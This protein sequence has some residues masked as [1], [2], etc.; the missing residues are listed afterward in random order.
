MKIEK[1]DMVMVYDGGG[2]VF[3]QQ[4]GRVLSSG[5][6][7]TPLVFDLCNNFA[8]ITVA[9]GT[10]GRMEKTY[11]EMKDAGEHPAFSP[12]DFKVVG[13]ALEIKQLAAELQSAMNPLFSIDDKISFLEK[14]ARANGGRL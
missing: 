11:R 12:S 13:K 10:C 5:G 4:L 3:Y 9:E 1:N 2:T 8:S 7:R 6:N 14:I